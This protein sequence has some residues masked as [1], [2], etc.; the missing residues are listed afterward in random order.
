[1]DYYDRYKTVG[2]VVIM[3]K[4][5]TNDGK[6]YLTLRPYL[7]KDK[8]AYEAYNNWLDEVDAFLARNGYNP[9]KNK[10]IIQLNKPVAI[11][12]RFYLR[13]RDMLIRCMYDYGLR[14]NIVRL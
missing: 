9:V 14:V 7:L 8:K 6:Y 13:I 1:M 2:N 12:G 10:G 5:G 4:K 3:L 11:E